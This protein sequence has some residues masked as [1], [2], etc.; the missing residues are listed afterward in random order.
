MLEELEK[1]NFEIN[2]DLGI[3]FDAHKIIGPEPRP[4]EEEEEGMFGR[5]ERRMRRPDEL[6]VKVFIINEDGNWSDCGI[7][8]LIFLTKTEIIVC[9]DD[10]N[11]KERDVIAPDRAKKL[12]GGHGTSS[13]EV[14]NSDRGE[15]LL[16]LDLKDAKDFMKSQSRS[17][18]FG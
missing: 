14:M 9:S 17:F 12:R 18:G 4:D 1:S 5:R 11:L 6:K 15:L 7:G 13:L 16:N 10:N 2:P 3:Q 8:T